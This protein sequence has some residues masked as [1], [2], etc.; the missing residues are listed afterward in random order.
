MSNLFKKAIAFTDIHFGNK[1]NSYAHNE[2]CVEFV[3]WIIKQGKEQKC[4]TCLFLGDWHH[5]RASINVATLNY[6]IDALTK[7][8]QAFDQVI[9]IPG[10]HDEYYRDK[11]DFNSVSWARHIPNL[12]FFNDITVEG[13]VAIVPWLVGDEYKQMHKLEAKYMIGHF[14]LPHFYMNAMVQMPDHGELKSDAFQGIERVFTGHFHK[15]QERKNISYIGN[16]FPH[17]YSDAGDDERGCMF[18]E[19][20]QPHVFKAWDNAPKYRVLKLSNL[21]DNPDKLLLPKTY[22]RIHLDIDISY[23]EANFIRETFSEQYDVRELALIPQK[24]IDTDFDETVDV[25]FESVDSIVISQLGSV[26]SDVYD[27]NLLMDIYR[28][29]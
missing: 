7:L 29:L 15:R 5:H 24:A 18:L 6:S 4:E 17:N 13:D 21:L 27:N 23:E 16:A 10:N 1:S 19:W 22:A 2:D 26:Q 8:S 14:E 11:R 3:D 20:G 28:N 9:F 25:N 12:R